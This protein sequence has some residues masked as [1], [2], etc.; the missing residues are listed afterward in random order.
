MIEMMNRTY[1]WFKNINRS[2]YYFNYFVGLVLLGVSGLN[3]HGLLGE[4]RHAPVMLC[5][6][7]FMLGMM[8][9]HGIDDRLQRLEKTAGVRAYHES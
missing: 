8:L 1:L 5:T 9:Y 3:Y 4:T 6:S 7:M 2:M